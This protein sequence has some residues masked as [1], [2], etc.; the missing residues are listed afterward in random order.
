VFDEADA[1]DP[2]A[3]ALIDRSANDLARLVITLGR[4]LGF[5]G[6]LPLAYTGSLLLEAGRFRQLVTTHLESAWPGLQPIL[7]DDP[8]LTAARYLAASS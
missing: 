3:T 5:T 8:A 2:V 6:R 1:C 7:V 4:R